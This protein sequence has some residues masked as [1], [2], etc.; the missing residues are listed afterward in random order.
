MAAVVS[1]TL[2]HG[3]LRAEFAPAF[4]GWLLALYS[5]E[6]RGRRDWLMPVPAGQPPGQNGCFPLVPFSNRI[7]SGRFRFQGRAVRLTP[8]VHTPPHALHGFGWLRPWALEQRTDAAATLVFRYDAGQEWPWP[9]LARQT[10]QLDD[11]GLQVTLALV[12]RAD[13]AMPAGLGLHP[14]FVR[15]PGMRLE[16]DWDWHW[17]TGP[18]RLPRGRQ[19]CP[20]ALS[21]RGG[22]TLFTG[23]DD[24]FSG[25]SRHA[26]L[27]WTDG[28]RLRITATAP[29][30][31]AV[32]Y[33][34]P[35][36]PVV[37]LEPVSHVNDAVNLAGRDCQGTGLRALA[38]GETLSASVW[39]TP[40]ADSR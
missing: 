22:R 13:S 36:C 15:R 34:P 27:H 20:K 24:C 10:L 28:R 19:R 17:P 9:F 23:V 39:L 14:Y 18:D 7:D 26:V 1:V 11:Q 29:L 4:G 32:L 2:Y 25:W 5:V 37:C 38:P 12:N 3:P 35:D 6:A 8:S 21:F 16:T 30:D 40:D 33:T 31:C